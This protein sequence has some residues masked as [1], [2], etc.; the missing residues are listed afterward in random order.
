MA[1]VH[2]WWRDFWPPVR[3]PRLDAEVPADGSRFTPEES[4][5]IERYHMARFV[6]AVARLPLKQCNDDAAVAA[7][8]QSH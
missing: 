4:L 3:H 1:N 7:G 6:E 2:P 5:V 8:V